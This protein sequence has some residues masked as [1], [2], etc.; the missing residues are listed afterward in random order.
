MKRDYLR[1]SRIAFLMG[2]LIV[3]SLSDAAPNRFASAGQSKGDDVI[4][5]P[6]PP[7][8]RP[9]EK[10]KS[11]PAKFN[12]QYRM[13]FVLI[14]AGKFMMGSADGSDSE[15][16][17]HG[18]A[19]A[20]AFYLGRYE[21]TQGQ[22]RAVTGRNVN[23]QQRMVAGGST[24]QPRRLA[25]VGD[26]YP[27][28]YVSWEETQHFIQ[29][30]NALNDGYLYRLPTEAEWEYACRAGGSSDRSADLNPIAWYKTNSGD[31]TH[32]VGMRRSNAFGLYDMLGNVWEWCEDWATTNY[33]GAAADGSAWL[34]AGD[35]KERSS[36][37]GSFHTGD[38]AFV[39]CT[40]RGA[41]TPEY[42]DFETGF[43]VVAVR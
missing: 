4:A 1:F 36:R 6:T 17:I 19:I 37:G 24:G 8:N 34:T 11:L 10:S 33:D 28:Y 38:L 30:L 25:G 42:R 9:A 15:K 26:D 32:P 2:G 41:E 29:R 27:I 21:V 23:E 13:E 43:R 40:A 12:N 7:P 22:W 39:R 18:V 16:P 3:L 35:L 20:R 31:S 14:P 5:K